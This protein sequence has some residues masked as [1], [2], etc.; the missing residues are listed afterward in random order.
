MK[1]LL[2]G[3]LVLL[4]SVAAALFALPDPGYIL[5]GYGNISVETS[6]VVFIIVLLVGYLALRMLA[7][8][9]RMPVR[10]RHWSGQRQLQ[11]LSRRY[12]AA[13]I[14]LV[15]GKLERAER[16]L[17]RLADDSRAPLAACLSAAH[18]ANRLGEDGRRDRYLGQALKRFPE[19]ES[20]ICLV[21]AELQLARDQFDQAQT[22]LAHLRTLMPRNRETLRLQMQLYLGQKDWGKLR[23]LLPE[24]RRSEV[25]NHDQWQRLAVQVYQERIRELTSARDI[26]TLKKGWAQLPPPVRQ[27][28][29]LL[30]LYIEQLVRLGEHDQAEGLLREQLSEYWDDRL[31]YLYGELEGCDSAVQ[32][33]MAE[34][35]LARHDKDAVLLL[36]LGK[37]SLRNKLWGKARSYLEASIGIQPTAEAYRLLGDLLE[38]LEDHDAAAECYRKGLSLPL[39]VLQAPAQV[40]PEEA[41]LQ[42]AETDRI[43]MLS[44]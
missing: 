42:A 14:E 31:V 32:Q 7:G 4:G 39:P 18:A 44:H 33:K 13:I 17:G 16:Q 5:I 25:L 9:W 28:H 20:A 15:S 10:I 29:A 38:Q 6:L 11:K 41:M 8:L 35:W 24:L 19:A 3:V 2:I 27:D 23:E 36:T 12:D 40:V 1:L 22:T 34:K 37:I 30:A 43:E 21:Q 26:D